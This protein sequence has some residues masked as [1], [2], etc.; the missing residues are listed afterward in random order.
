MKPAPF[1]TIESV[2]PWNTLEE[3]VRATTLLGQPEV[4][5]YEH[6][7][8]TLKRIRFADIRTTSL[9]VSRAHLQVQAQIAQDIHDQ[10]NYDP[11]EQSSG[12][13]LTSTD[14]TGQ[15]LHTALVP[16]I[17]EHSKADG[18]YVLD[19]SHRLN[20]GR[21][22]GRDSFMAIVIS[23]IDPKYPAYAH[24][25]N[26]DEVVMYD[27]PP[28]DPALRKRYRVKPDHYTLYRDFGTLN[29]SRP[30]YGTEK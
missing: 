5:P 25:N 2:I 18:T 11:L 26:W 6:A 13:I 7:V 14:E 22:A 24:P 9:Y 1:V 3:R 27:E 16:P 29:G 28:R 23:D 17:L 20:I 21:W 12:L 10:G 19:G 4:R 30:R 8:I 15:L